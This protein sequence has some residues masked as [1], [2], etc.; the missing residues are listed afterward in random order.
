MSDWYQKLSNWQE[1]QTPRVP[2]TIVLPHSGIKP[3]PP[4]I[5]PHLTC[6]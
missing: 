1:K 5:P 4:P 6:E 3:V 2:V